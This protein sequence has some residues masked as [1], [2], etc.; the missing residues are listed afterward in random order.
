MVVATADPIKPAFLDRGGAAR[1]AVVKHVHRPS[2][3]LGPGVVYLPGIG[4]S[5][6]GCGATRAAFPP[7]PC[8]PPNAHV[9]ASGTA[10]AGRAACTL[11]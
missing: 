5:K 3:T 2:K 7:T 4:S 11:K 6:D 9:T 8:L 1:L 10:P